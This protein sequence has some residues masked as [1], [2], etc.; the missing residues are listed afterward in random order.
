MRMDIF[1]SIYISVSSVNGK[2]FLLL[3][4]LWFTS[5]QRLPCLFKTIFDGMN[6]HFS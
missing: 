4:T 3:R 2:L 1:S 5:V 6:F